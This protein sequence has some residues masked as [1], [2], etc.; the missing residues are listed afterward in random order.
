[1]S[2]AD[3]IIVG[4]SLAGA[5][6]A[7][8]LSIKRQLKITIIDRSK[9]E[10]IGKKCCGDVFSRDWKEN[11]ILTPRENE[12]YGIWK[13]QYVIIQ[14][15]DTYAKSPFTDALVV[16]RLK[17][18]QRLLKDAE[19]NGVKI[20]PD[21]KVI[22]TIIEDDYI[23]GIVA[24]NQ[25]TKEEE[26]F[27]AKLIAD[28]S[29]FAHVVR[30]NIPETKFPRL[31]KKISY[32]VDGYREILKVKK[33]L[34]TYLYMN[35]PEFLPIGSYFWLMSQGKGRVNAGIY[36]R[37]NE[38]KKEKIKIVDTFKKILH[39][40]YYTED[41][42]EVEDASGCPIPSVIPL[43]NIVG[44][45]FVTFGDAGTQAC[46]LVGEG[47]RYAL[48][49]GESI[50]EVIIEA[51]EKGDL[52]ESGLW[53]SNK[54]VQDITITNII[55]YFRLMAF[56]EFGTEGLKLLLERIPDQIGAFFLN[57]KLSFFEQLNAAFK[58][59]EKNILKALIKIQLT[60]RKLKK[61]FKEYPDSPENYSVW[62][63]KFLDLVDNF[64]GSRKTLLV[65]Q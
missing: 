39:K 5:S 64:E 9:R 26:T 44:N 36:L 13:N 12:I 19:N 54:V 10:E 24:I 60:T 8:N 16:N 56:K 29:G 1:M 3:V 30:K 52:S 7:V 58:L 15:D 23:V 18:N 55:A 49:T 46:P 53:E 59:R 17:Y 65:S 32:M 40:Q 28:T 27:R 6:L 45:G 25:E 4:G 50:S 63:E 57:E 62:R 37:N 33:D 31:E 21:R 47:N 22:R 41:Q 51:F 20:I 61:L 48:L 38:T 42:Y 14:A 11:H 43:T 35:L 34:E 2:E